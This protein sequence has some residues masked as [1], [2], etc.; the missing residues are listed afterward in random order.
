M[1]RGLHE[2]VSEHLLLDSITNKYKEDSVRKQ[3]RPREQFVTCVLDLW[4][5]CRRFAAMNV[6]WLDVDGDQKHVEGTEHKSWYKYDISQPVHVSCFALLER[7][8]RAQIPPPRK[9]LCDMAGTAWQEQLPEAHKSYAFSEET[10]TV[11]PTVLFLAHVDA[12]GTFADRMC[13]DDDTHFDKGALY[14]EI[15]RGMKKLHRAC[16]FG[17]AADVDRQ[18]KAAMDVIS[19]TFATSNQMTPLHVDAKCGLTL[20]IDPKELFDGGFI[21]PGSPLWWQQSSH[22]RR[23]RCRPRLQIDA[24]ISPELL[25]YLSRV[26]TAEWMLTELAVCLCDS[27]DKL[28]ALVVQKDE[29]DA[30]K[31]GE[32]G[33]ECVSSIAQPLMFALL[34]NHSPP[35]L[36]LYLRLHESGFSV[37][38]PPRGDPDDLESVSKSCT[39][40]WRPR[41]GAICP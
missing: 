3:Q 38:D 15:L 24:G 28:K 34:L 25:P 30:C 12:L 5:R 20:K 4:A 14:D 6:T 23:R 16:D 10:G 31:Y 35:A 11:P 26:A 32:S 33:P 7:H 1:E 36:R 13:K 17:I 2:F 41:D 37:W 39:S 40:R 19:Y 18:A 29:R 9:L 8:E 27:I 22:F 21:R